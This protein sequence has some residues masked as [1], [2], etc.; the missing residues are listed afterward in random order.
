MI[1]LLGYFIYLLCFLS[2]LLA[3]G[4]GLAWDEPEERAWTRQKTVLFTLLTLALYLLAK[5]LLA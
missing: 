3:V 2:L 5:T 4:N 1:T